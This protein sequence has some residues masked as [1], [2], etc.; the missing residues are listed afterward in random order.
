MSANQH[1]AK[2]NCVWI[3][4]S[5]VVAKPQS[6]GH[7]VVYSPAATPVVTK[8]EMNSAVIKQSPFGKITIASQSA[9]CDG[10]Q[11]TVSEYECVG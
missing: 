7:Y 2:S 11:V 9:A 3:K 8:L 10:T 1:P 6:T 4:D 5:T